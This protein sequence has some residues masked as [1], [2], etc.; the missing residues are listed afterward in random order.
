MTEFTPVS[1]VLGG[2]LIGS[3]AALLLLGLGRI[4][5]ISGILGRFLFDGG[6]QPWQL[7]F[8]LGLPLGAAGVAL[9]QGGLPV[10]I[11][12]SSKRP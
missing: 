9:L 4:A 7:A 5:G 8:L 3:A 2:I 1:A 6:R 12:A 11:D 10:R